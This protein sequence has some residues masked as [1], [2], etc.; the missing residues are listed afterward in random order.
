MDDANRDR[1]AFEEDARDNG[2]DDYH[3][4]KDSAGNYRQDQTRWYWDVWRAALA[5]R[6]AQQQA[7]LEAVDAELEAAWPKNQGEV[8]ELIKST[9]PSHHPP[10]VN[11][12]ELEELRA[13]KDSAMSVEKS[14]DV[15]A[16]ASLIG[17]PPG[18][19]IRSAIQ[20]YIEKQQAE[21][22]RLLTLASTINDAVELTKRIG[23]S[24]MT[25]PVDGDIASLAAA[26]IKAKEAKDGR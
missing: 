15:Q 3:L 9:M 19:D 10:P 2:A 25:L 14:W 5:H 16:I 4:E 1:E 8:D 18:G 22:D 26:A 17:V 11:Q 13:W 23:R 20:P 6:D 24:T 7:E 21:L 12:T